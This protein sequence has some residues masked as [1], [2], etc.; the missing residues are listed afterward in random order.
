MTD[1]RP[2]MPKPLKALLTAMKTPRGCVLG[3]PELLTQLGGRISDQETLYLCQEREKH[4]AQEVSGTAP[5]MKLLLEIAHI[6]NWTDA[7]KDTAEEGWPKSMNRLDVATQ[8]FHSLPNVTLLCPDSHKLYDGAHNPFEARTIE[9]A[10]GLMWRRPGAD[11][12]L[13]KFINSLEFRSGHQ[14]DLVNVGLAAELLQQHRGRRDLITVAPREK[15]YRSLN[16]RV[17]FPDD[18]NAFLRMGSASG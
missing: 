15:Q 17:H 4:E 9:V 8:R 3:N 13:R 16:S 12:P 11:R 18:G 10:T 14:P 1:D 2:L 5:V 7:K 6:R